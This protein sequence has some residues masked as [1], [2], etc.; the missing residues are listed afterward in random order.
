MVKA[1]SLIPIVALSLILGLMSCGQKGPS[2]KTATKIYVI[3]STEKNAEE[4]VK[5]ILKDACQGVSDSEIPVEIQF[6]QKPNLDG[7]ILL[8]PGCQMRVGKQAKA[9]AAQVKESPLAFSENIVFVGAGLDQDNRPSAIF[10]QVDRTD[11][12]AILSVENHITKIPRPN[13]ASWCLTYVG[14]AFVLKRQLAESLKEYKNIVNS[15]EIE[16]RRLG[17]CKI[18]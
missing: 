4:Y 15:E 10:T 1:Y 3:L 18:P 16:S 12:T 17:T 6:I 2:N 13:M 9:I 14:E 5:R 11:K 8:K 7:K